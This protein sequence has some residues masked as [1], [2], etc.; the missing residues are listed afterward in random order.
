MKEQRARVL[1]NSIFLIPDKKAVWDGGG[2]SRQLQL[3][4]VLREVVLEELAVVG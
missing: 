4:Q 3:S 1:P 2:E